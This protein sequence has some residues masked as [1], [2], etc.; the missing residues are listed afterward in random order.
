MFKWIRIL[1]L[2]FL[3][4]CLSLC[5]NV[6][7]A[8][9]TDSP[10]LFIYDASGSMWGKIGSDYKK[11]IASEVL[12]QTIDQLEDEQKIGLIAYGHRVKS[13]CRDVEEMIDINNRDKSVLKSTIKTIN[14]LGKTPLAYSAEIAIEKIRQTSSSTTI[15]LITD[16]IESCNGNLCKVIQLAKKEGIEFKLH[17][18]GF[19][20]KEGDIEALKC[21]TKEGDGNYYDAKDANQ[22]SKSLNSALNEKVD[23]PAPNHTFHITKNGIPIDA[24]IKLKNIDTGK[25]IRGTRTY[26]DTATAFIPTGKY[27]ITVNPLGGSDVAKKTFQ[28]SKSPEGPSHTDISFDG[29]E[30][31]IFVSNNNEAWDATIR[32]YDS[33]TQKLVAAKRTYGRAATLELNEGIFYIEVLPLNIKGLD[34]KYRFENVEVVA[35]ELVSLNHNYLTGKLSVG[36]SLNSGELVDA[37]V[38]VN[39]KESNQNIT[40]SRTYTSSSSNPKTIIILPGTYE[41]KINTLGVH[42]GITKTEILTVVPNKTSTKIFKID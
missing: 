36:V 29:G 1:T 16:G 14:P 4:Q 25:E 20:I 38:K 34:L 2:C 9:S 15:I 10:I 33:N 41:V 23:D 13:D 8:Q 12:S 17:I 3:C 6:V 35:N 19:G 27:Q 42:K 28:F 21:A 30:I 24:W 26:K 32:V 39:N 31:E 18:V 5:D 7:I 11:D 40:G 37:V 22:L